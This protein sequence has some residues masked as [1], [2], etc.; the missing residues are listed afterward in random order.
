[1]LLFFV[2]GVKSGKTQPGVCCDW[3]GTDA[4]TVTDRLLSGKIT[5]ITVSF[6]LV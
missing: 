3:V 4:D 5:V 2:A 6:E 1:M